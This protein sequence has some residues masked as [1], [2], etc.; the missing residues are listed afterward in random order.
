MELFARTCKGRFVWIS[1]WKIDCAVFFYVP[2]SAFADVIDLNSK[3]IITII[4]R[5]SMCNCLLNLPKLIVL[6][7]SYSILREILTERIMLW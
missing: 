2:L 3:L 4:N 6:M 1:Q 5:Y 7:M